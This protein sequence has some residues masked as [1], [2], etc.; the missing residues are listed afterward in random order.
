MDFS[1]WGYKKSWLST[2]T[3]RALLNIRSC[4]TAQV[5]HPRHHGINEIRSIVI[6]LLILSSYL[7]SRFVSN[8]QTCR[9]PL[10]DTHKYYSIIL[11]V[12]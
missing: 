9:P 3:H 4:V 8:S 12:F 11:R 1:P 2:R 5:T 10:K 6:A 7:Y